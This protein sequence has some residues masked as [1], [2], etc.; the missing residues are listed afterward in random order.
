MRWAAQPAEPTTAPDYGRSGLAGRGR[1]RPHLV[2]LLSDERVT[3]KAF[4][5]SV[6]RREWCFPDQSTALSEP[7]EEASHKG[8]LPDVNKRLLSLAW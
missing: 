1:F 3:G 4:T 6:K 7:V 8:P 5:R 2:V